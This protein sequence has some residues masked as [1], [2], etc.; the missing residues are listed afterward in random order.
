VLLGQYQQTA[1]HLAGGHGHT[2]V[3][4]ILLEYK[5]DIDCKDQV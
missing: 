5:A 1:L 2:V 3:V 4:N